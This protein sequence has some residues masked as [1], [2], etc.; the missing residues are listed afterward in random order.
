MCHVLHV[1]YL[2]HFILFTATVRLTTYARCWDSQRRGS[3]TTAREKPVFSISDGKPQ[4]CGSLLVADGKV[5][6]VFLLLPEWP[7]L[8]QT[9]EQNAPRS[10]LSQCTK[11][12]AMCGIIIY[13]DKSVTDAAAIVVFHQT[14]LLCTL[15]ALVVPSLASCSHWFQGGQAMTNYHRW[16]VTDLSDIYM[17][18]A[19]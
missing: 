2:F 17:Y 16:W 11:G 4:R 13:L 10:L 9:F 5:I 14:T 7:I 3:G 18:K 19:S 1:I 12:L 15:H 8:L 6:G